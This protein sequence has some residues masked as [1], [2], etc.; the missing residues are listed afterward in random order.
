MFF[1][2]GQH[3]Q[4][5][6]GER[7]RDD[8]LGEHL[9][10]L[11][12]HRQVDLAVGRDHAAEG[13]HRVA[14]VRLA[15]RR[16][17]VG[18]DGDAARVGVLDDRH[19]GVGVVVRGP[20]GGVGVDVVVVGHRLAVQLL[21]V[22]Q[23]RLPVPVE[24]GPLVRVL[25]VAQHVGPV[26]ARAHPGREAAVVVGGQDVAHPRGDGDVVARGVP[27]GGRGQPLPLGQ[28]EA[29]GADGGEHLG[30]PGRVDDDGDR[31]VVL[32]RGAHHRRPAD[33]DLLHALVGARARGH[34]L[35]E[36]VEVDDHEVER[37]DAELLEL[38]DVL[39]LA[40]VGE[41]A[42]VHG[43]VQRLH[44]AVEALGEAGDLLDGGDRHAR[45]GDPAGR[46]AGAHQ[47][48]A[49]GGQ[50]AGELLDPGLVVDAEQGAA[51]RLVRS[52]IGGSSSPSDGG[53]EL[54][55]RLH[56]ELALHV[57]DP[58]VQASPRRRRAG[59]RPRAGPAPGRCPR[60]RRR[61]ARSR[62]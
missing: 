44:P 50:P 38:R 48:H 19:A 58:L 22:R 37:R 51:D 29:A 11:L 47:L 24:R 33:V 10:D 16:G 26:P 31:R 60:R 61:R 46:R 4:R 20:P 49:G 62:R 56:Q 42:G 23:P 1:L 57:L 5:V 18:A 28:G 25:A 9:G 41:D 21:G 54:G 17:D 6:V 45:V 34:R 52:V 12:G 14:G 53:R 40:P 27:E 3:G 30:V 43:G 55:H 7:R 39:G 32:R 59:R 2:R 35:G 15:V 36:R 13:R 8:H